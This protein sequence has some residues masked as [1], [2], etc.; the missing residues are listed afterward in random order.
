M[1]LKLLNS[2]SLSVSEITPNL[3][4]VSL[5][6]LVN[7]RGGGGCVN[8]SKEPCSCRGNYVKASYSSVK[9]SRQSVDWIGQ[10][11]KFGIG[12]VYPEDGKKGVWLKLRLDRSE[13]VPVAVKGGFKYH[14]AEEGYLMLT[15][16]IPEGPCMLSF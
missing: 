9:R 16:W 7:S 13:L 8:I 15:Y 12:R 4:R 1:E 11:N 2:K 6:S 3:R 10:D 14:H 5:N